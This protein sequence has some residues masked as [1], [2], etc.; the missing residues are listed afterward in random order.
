MKNSALQETPTQTAAQE[1]N[2]RFDQN[3]VKLTGAL[4]NGAWHRALEV[5]RRLVASGVWNGVDPIAFDAYDLHNRLFGVAREKPGDLVAGQD[6][7]I[8]HAAQSG[9]HTA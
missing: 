8:R 9:A 7:R 4:H 1:L 3:A 6:Y 2:A 5:A